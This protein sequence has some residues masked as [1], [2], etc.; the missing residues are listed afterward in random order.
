MSKR[1]TKT[2][3]VAVYPDGTE[4]QIH[5]RRGGWE[6]RRRCYSSHYDLAVS[7]VEQGGGR[8]E[9][10][11]NPQYREPSYY[12]VLMRRMFEA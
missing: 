8:V 12:E 11:P 10:R 6:Y 9:R 7:L 1:I 5:R 3:P 4:W 2:I